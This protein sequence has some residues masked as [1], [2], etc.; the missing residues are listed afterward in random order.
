MI[1][2][3]L[4][5]LVGTV[6]LLVAGVGKLRHPAGTG[7]A[8]RTQG[9]PSATAL[10]RGLGVAE[11]A[12][13]AG[14]AA[15][16]AVAAWANAVAYAGFTGF[17]LLAL[18]RRRPL[19]SCG[20]FGEPDLPPTGAHVVLTAVLA[21]AAALAAAGPSRGLP[22]LLALPAGATVAALVL[23]GLL[24]ALCLLVL[25]GLPRLVAARPPTRRTTS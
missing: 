22:A 21:G 7:R 16:L 2:A 20:C 14:S 5:F 6:L 10:V 18:L 4:P 9:L 13:A 25:T 17:V 1:A 23:T 8:L 24:C 3:Q 19:S 11:L 12:V 15:G